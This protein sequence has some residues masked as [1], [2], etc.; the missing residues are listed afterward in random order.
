MAMC[1]FFV[2]GTQRKFN[3]K[4][5]HTDIYSTAFT[6]DR[7][8]KMAGEQR[9]YETGYQALGSYY[10]DEP[11]HEEAPPADNI[12]HVVPDKNKCKIVQLLTNYEHVKINFV[13]IC[14]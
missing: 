7:Y 13:N 11:D 9:H 14:D 3:V 2:H 12:I 6:F 4:P 5:E 10:D 1:L 8:T